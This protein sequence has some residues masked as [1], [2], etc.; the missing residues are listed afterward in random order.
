MPKVSI[1][2]P[3]YNGARHIRAA[4]D[5]VLAQDFQDFELI[6]VD[7]NSS[8]E[9][10][11][12]VAACADPRVRLE[13]NSVN[14]GPEGNWNRAVSLAHGA[15]LKLLPQ[16]DLLEPGGLAAQV[17]VLDADPDE[18]I[19]LV[20]GA[21][22]I[23][24]AQGKVIARRGCAGVEPGRV[25]AAWLARQS[26]RKG[27]N[28]I[29]E[30]GAVLFRRSLSERI[31]GFDGSQGFVIDLDY[32]LR[33]LAHGDGYYMARPV[34]S[35]RVSRGSWSVAIGARQSQEYAAFLDRMRA[36]GLV[37]ASAA[38]LAEGKARAWLNNVLRLIFY[39]VIVR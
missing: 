33:L 32:W 24:D 35:F 9:T 25:P 26:V 1:V 10:A 20:F 34:S 29:G 6:V 17:A 39:K 18:A 38:E 19:A 13:C 36:A 27:T 4:I 14:L 30:P 22:R 2:M 15:Y 8:D 11:A 16:D 23:I 21:R 28:V 7:D 31:G 5:S 37:R 12:V 3:A